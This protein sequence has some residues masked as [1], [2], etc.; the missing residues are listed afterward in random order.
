MEPAT[1]NPL[2]S[3]PFADLVAVRMCFSATPMEGCGLDRAVEEE[4]AVRMMRLHGRWEDWR[5]GRSAADSAPSSSAASTASVP[6]PPPASNPGAN[7]T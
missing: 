1:T 5:D 6:P 3:M 4:I 2:L 7:L